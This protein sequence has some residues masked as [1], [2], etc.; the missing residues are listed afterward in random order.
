VEVTRAKC[1][2]NYVSD[3]GNQECRPFFEKPSIGI[4]SESHFIIS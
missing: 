4:G 1:Q 2:I 3:S